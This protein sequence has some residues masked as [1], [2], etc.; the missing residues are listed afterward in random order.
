MKT[1]DCTYL[2]P[3]HKILRFLWQTDLDSG[4]QELISVWTWIWNNSGSLSFGVYLHYCHPPDSKRKAEGA[5]MLPSCCS[6]HHSAYITSLMSLQHLHHFIP[7]KEVP[8]SHFAL[9]RMYYTADYVCLWALWHHSTQKEIGDGEGKNEKSNPKARVQTQSPN[10]YAGSW[11]IGLSLVSIFLQLAT[12]GE[13]I[14]YERNTEIIENGE[15]KLHYMHVRS[16]TQSFYT[17]KNWIGWSVWDR[18]FLVEFLW[19]YA[20]NNKCDSVSSSL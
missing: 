9:W 19:T 20:M 14:I 17:D 2:Y 16:N 4:Q 13:K 7:G 10:V 11:F 6:C 8:K 1:V 5:M 18:L 15:M 12:R 3:V